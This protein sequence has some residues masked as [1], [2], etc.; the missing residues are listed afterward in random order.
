[1][2]FDKITQADLTGKGVIGLTDTPQLPTMQMQ[3]KL[4]EI[5][6]DVIVPKFNAV[7]DKLND[8]AGADD[9][10]VTDPTTGEQVSLNDA[11]QNIEDENAENTR[12]RHNHANLGTLDEIT[13]ATKAEYDRLVTLLGAITAIQ[14]VLSGATD[15]IP[16]GKATSDA[17]QTV[18]DEVD[19]NTL[20]RHTHDNKATL[21]DITAQVKQGYDRIVTLLTG[22]MGVETTLTNANDK[23]ARS[24]AVYTAISNLASVVALNTA[25]RH[26][27][28]NKATLD[29]IDELT[30]QGYDNVS[31]LLTG[32]TGIEATLTNSNDKI[33]RSDAVYTAIDNLAQ[34]V[35]LNTDARHTHANKTTL[36]AIDALTKQAYDALVTTFSGKT[37]EQTVTNDADKLPSGAAVV[38]YVSS[39]GG[40]DML[41]SR[42]D[43]NDD[44]TVDSADYATNAGDSTRLG[45]L[46]SSAYA[47]TTD[48]QKLFGDI[49]TYQ[50]TST[51]AL[52]AYAI[53]DFMIYNNYF[54]EVTQAI[55]QGG[56]IVVNTNI[57]QVTV[58][59]VLA[60][61]GKVMTGATSLLDGAAGLVPAPAAGNQGKYLRGDGTWQT[62]TNTTTGD[63]IKT[64]VAKTGTAQASVSTSISANTTMDN[65]IGTLL[66]NDATLDTHKLGDFTAISDVTISG[67]TYHTYWEVAPTASNQV[68]GVA[69]F[70]TNGKLTRIYNN[71]G[72]YSA[73]SYD[74]NTTTGD[75]IKTK[76]AK[77]GTAQSAINP[78][79]SAGT[80]LDN[81]IGTLLNNDATLNAEISDIEEVENVSVTWESGYQDIG[82]TKV[83][84]KNG[85]LYVNLSIQILNGQFPT[86]L[87]KVATLSKGPDTTT[88]LSGVEA[89]SNW[90]PIGD[91]L[92]LITSD[93]SVNLA[94]TG[95]SGGAF[96]CVNGTAPIS[97]Q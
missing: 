6:L 49:A 71:K 62:P 42:Y 23:I 39:L 2:A 19:L 73:V 20:A 16:T 52:R 75:G 72:A 91:A 11:L 41:K 31:T 32:I 35:A 17:I 74:A 87:T 14:N 66:N 8:P 59:E 7:M 4:D 63:G 34:I 18:Q 69:V 51:V 9:T 25:A 77:T 80:T 24:D 55:S 5:A 26:T 78:T 70:P 85:I 44:G 15:E 89:N 46:L 13:A 22:I 3:Q 54:Y 27:H 96:A 43:T 29:T 36:D 93:G 58:G 1:M 50:G 28:A 84:I 68:Y 53:G 81:A 61:L 90:G 45:G 65:S 40:G 56:S 97:I 12:N 86:S 47:S 82:T 60:R 64:K 30:K 10:Q 67:V 21:D 76:V 88:V 92:A 83:F 33:A 48:V 95:E 38:A 79:L 57:T 94:T 37:V